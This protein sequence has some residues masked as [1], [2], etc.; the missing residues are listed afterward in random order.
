MTTSYSKK[1]FE[2]RFTKTSDAIKYISELELL[3]LRQI[4]DEE[5]ENKIDNYFK[6]IPYTGATIPVGVELFRARINVGDNPFDKVKDIYIPPTDLIT[7]YG[8]ANRP[9]EQIFYSASNFKQASFE[10][11]QNLK[12]SIAPDRQV[13][14]LT[15]GI[16]R[17]KEELHLTN[18]INSPVLHSLRQDIV[19]AFTHNQKLLNNGILKEDIVNANNLISQ[20]FS[21]QFTKDKIKSH[22][23][24]KISAFYVRRLKAMNKLIADKHQSAKFDGVNYPS[25]AMK[26]KGDNQAIFIESATKKLE[27]VN[28]IQVLCGNLN[29]DRG[30]FLPG[31]LHEAESIIDGIIKWKSEI[32][33]PKTN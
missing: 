12:Y 2:E 4:S 3:D 8:R 9:N 24:Y 13:V 20:F 11:I 19:E 6:L 17:V 15:I 31:V 27:L 33:T 21:D 30:D 23:D 22:H 16:W 14:F 32:Y 26:Y 25:V 7:E 28:T 18:I 10:V 1:E 5:L 29:F